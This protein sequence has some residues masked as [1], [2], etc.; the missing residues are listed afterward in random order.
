MK[1]VI[2][3]C[4]GGFSLSR[5]GVLLGREISGD[6]KWGG[7]NIIGDVYEGGKPV[8]RDYGYVQHY[9][10]RHDPTLV[11]V[12]ETLGGERASGELA[13]LA[14]VEIPD[15]ISYEIDEYDGIESIHES[16]RSWG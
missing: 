8:E 10:E 7:A 9:L 12:V 14:V 5:E 6:P 2:N 1:V 16:Y 11:K 13:E 4:Y 15:V 3:R